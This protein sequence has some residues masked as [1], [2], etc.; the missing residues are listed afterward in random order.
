MRVLVVSGDR[1]MFQII[2]GATHV[3]FL[4]QRGKPPVLYDEGK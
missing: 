1:D 2:D 3:L 4:G